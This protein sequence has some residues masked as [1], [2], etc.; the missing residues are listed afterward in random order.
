MGATAKSAVAAA[1]SRLPWLGLSLYIAWPFVLYYSPLALPSETSFIDLS[2]ATGLSALTLAATLA[3]LAFARMRTGKIE[4]GGVGVYAA[5]AVTSLGILL[6]LLCDFLLLSAA[7][8]L[9][10][11]SGAATGIG[12]SYIMVHYSI[13]YSQL[14]DKAIA[15]TYSASYFVASILYLVELLLP[16]ALARILLLLFPLASLRSL[17]ASLEQPKA[18][19][20]AQP[21]TPRSLLKPLAKILVSVFVFG[22]IFGYQRGIMTDGIEGNAQMN[23]V[24]YFLAM[25][26]CAITLSV[27]HAKRTKPIST[28]LLYKVATV[29]MAIGLVCLTYLPDGGGLVASICIAAAYITYELSVLLMLSSHA[30]R[31]KRSRLVVFSFGHAASHLGMALGV[32]LGMGA[33]AAG[34]LSSQAVQT[35]T[36]A[37]GLLVLVA[38]MFMFSDIDTPLVSSRD[39]GAAADA[40]SRRAETCDKLATTYNLS[41]REREVLALLLEGRNLPAIQE[42]LCLS[43]STVKTHKRHVYEKIGV[44]SQQELLDRADAIERKEP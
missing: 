20:A 7:E 1:R 6:A 37:V 8:P 21:Q 44:H 12:S 16:A 27:L 40:T 33:T 28:T 43:E 34:G 5:G 11:A 4:V 31:T 3:V 14:D 13:L 15:V 23:S 30:R 22:L 39:P 29:V 10:V 25:A 9:I 42:I 41:P 2:L 24:V 38:A 35:T 36:A 32:F 17:N 26:V 19:R 18:T